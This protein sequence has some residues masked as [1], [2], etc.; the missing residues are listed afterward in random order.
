MRELI[1]P[2]VTLVLAKAPAAFKDKLDPFLR[3]AVSIFNSERTFCIGL[4][5]KVMS[6]SMKT[7]NNPNIEFASVNKSEEIAL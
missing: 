4:E 1:I 7:Y 3:I 2:L 5:S 6:V